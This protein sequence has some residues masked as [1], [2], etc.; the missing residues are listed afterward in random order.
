ML[1]HRLRLDRLT[2]AQL[3]SLLVRAQAL[4]LDRP[5][6]DVDLSVY[7]LSR[8]EARLMALYRALPLE[9]RGESQLRVEQVLSALRSGVPSSAGE[10]RAPAHTGASED[11]WGGR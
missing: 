11:T 2:D 8:D 4:L 7:V 5:N 6:Q 1:I 3:H 9:R 10:D